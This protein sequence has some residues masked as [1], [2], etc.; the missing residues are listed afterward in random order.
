MKQEC[1]VNTLLERNHWLTDSFK[2][3]VFYGF[4]STMNLGKQ[5]YAKA[6]NVAFTYDI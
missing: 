6:C 4:A 1:G 5:T 2:H 3:H